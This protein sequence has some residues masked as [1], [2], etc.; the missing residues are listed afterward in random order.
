MVV[1]IPAI[2]S[3]RP[4][5]L[6]TTP[7]HHHPPARCP[8]VT[9]TVARHRVLSGYPVVGDN[10][11]AQVTYGDQY[12]PTPF[13]FGQTTLPGSDRGLRQQRTGYANCNRGGHTLWEPSNTMASIPMVRPKRFRYSQRYQCRTLANM[14]KFICTGVIT[15]DASGSYTFRAFVPEN[16]RS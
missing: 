2:T 9:T 13:P 8:T 1:V 14:Q 12:A 4:S 15:T 6:S 10:C 11:T 3:Y 5:L 7:P 16:I